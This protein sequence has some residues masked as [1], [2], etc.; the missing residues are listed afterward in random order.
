MKANI[1]KNKESGCYEQD[2]GV[3]EK[4][5]LQKKKFT[6]KKFSE[7]FHNTPK[8]KDQVLKPHSKLEG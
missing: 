3:P 8:A 4:L 5:C 7:I 2:G 1:N 6:L